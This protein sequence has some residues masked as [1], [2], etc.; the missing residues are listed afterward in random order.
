M[1]AQ[2]LAPP[3]NPYG[4]APPANPPPPQPILASGA[5][6]SGASG[7]FAIRPGA[8]VHV[9]RDPAQCPV[10]LQEPRVSGVHATMKFEQGQLWVRDENSNN[11]THIAGARIAAG[12]WVPVPAGSQLRFGPVEFAVR[13]DA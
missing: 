12:T 10:T 7:T 9:G 8:E 3:P 5:I 1:N 6:I 4:N 2:P 13:L 11:G